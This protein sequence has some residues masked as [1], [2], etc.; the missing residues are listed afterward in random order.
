MRKV[1]MLMAAMALA[2]G[3]GCASLGRRAFTEPVVSIKTLRLNGVGLNGGSLDV[4]LNVY[5]PN[6][7]RL[8]A[9]RL[10]YKLMLDSIPFGTGTA[11]SLFT[12]GSKD[13]TAIRLPLDFTWAGVGEAG[14]Q[15]INT[16]TVQYHVLGDLTVGSPVGSFTVPYDRRGRVSTLRGT[17]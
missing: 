12:V 2:A 7:F 9:S 15:L 13:S 8:D 11:D 17:N 3:I 4:V 16:G 14:R 5:N 1:G 10:T 6:G